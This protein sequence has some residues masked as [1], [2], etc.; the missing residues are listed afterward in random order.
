MERGSWRGSG[1]DRFSARGA[2]EVSAVSVKA[3]IQVASS[4]V[5]RT[6]E[7]A[8]RGGINGRL[9]QLGPEQGWGLPESC[10]GSVCSKLICGST[11]CVTF[12]AGECRVT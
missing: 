5:I 7:T 12:L 6:E 3:E 10:A 2:E 1:A 9:E 11:V 8:G 4:P